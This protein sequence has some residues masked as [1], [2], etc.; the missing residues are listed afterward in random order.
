MGAKIYW[1]EVRPDISAFHPEN[2][3]IFTAGPA[4]GTAAPSANRV[5]I[6]GK[7]PVPYPIECYLYSSMG[8]HWGAE[9]KF[10]GYDG[11]ISP[12]KAPKPVYLWIMDG[13]VEV[14]DAQPLWGMISREAQL[15]IKRM[16]G[17]NVRSAVIGPA[18]EHL[19]REA[20]IT[21]DTAFAAGLGGF[22]AVMGSKN[23]KAIAVRG[24][25]CVTV[26]KPMELI[27]LYDHFAR[28]ATCKPGE[29][30]RNPVRYMKY[31]T[32]SLELPEG[33]EVDEVDDSAMGEEIANGLAKKWSSSCFACPV[34]CLVGS[35][36]RITPSRAGPGAV[37]KTSL[38][39]T[40]NMPTTAARQWEGP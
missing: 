2:R 1:D 10:A 7:S 37:M 6:A 31:Y 39:S 18:G 21:S 22:G 16:H 19:C 35:S 23:L 34:G 4:V 24:T 30:R 17:D 27:D 12:G 40:P 15:A 26:A 13:Q 3:L 28:L 25:G 38:P 33:Q 32:S 14:R 5:F 8:E 36:S 9:L 20:I 29:G 11:L